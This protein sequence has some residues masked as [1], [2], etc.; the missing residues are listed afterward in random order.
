MDTKAFYTDGEKMIDDEL[1]KMRA[2]KKRLHQISQ[3]IE[4]F[5]DGKL[6]EKK[7]RVKL[8]RLKYPLGDE[9]PRTAEAAELA[10]K[11]KSYAAR[12]TAKKAELTDELERFSGVRKLRGEFLIDRNIVSLF[13]SVLTRTLGIPTA[14]LTRDLLVVKTC[15]FKILHDIVLNG[16]EWDGE[17]YVYFTAS[18][19]QIRTKRSVFIRESQLQKYGEKLM[20]GLSVEKINEMGGVNTNKYLAYLALCNSATDPWPGFDITKTIVV[21]DMETV[22]TGE[23]DYIDPET[24]QITRKVMGVP[25]THT[26]GCGMVRPDISKKNFMIRLPWVKGLLISFPFDKFVREQR[27]GGNTACG[28]VTDIYG[29][30]HDVLAED[31]QVIFTKS[32]F[33]LWKYYLGGWQEYQTKFLELGCEAGVCNVEPDHFDAAKINYQMLQTLKDLS[34]EELLSIGSNTINKLRRLS[35]DRETMLQLFG[36]TNQDGRKS[37]FQRCLNLYPE[38]L[39]DE[40]T[41]RTLRDV[42]KSVE[43]EARAGKLYV[44]GV[45]TFI[46][47]DLYAFC[48]WLFLGDENPSGLLRD[49][50]VYCDLFQAEKLDCLRAPHLSMEHA[51]RRNMVGTEEADE[52]KRWF[53][54]PAVYTSVNDLISKILQFD[55]DGDRSLVVAD[56]TIIAAAERN[57]RGVV[58]MYYEMKKAAAQQITSENIYQSMIRA[59]TG[60]N[61][62]QISNDITK[63]WNTDQEFSYEAIQMLCMENNF[64]IDRC[65]RTMQ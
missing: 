48:Q 14:Q 24:Y 10:A 52:I 8:E 13:E 21:D 31:I 26:D 33:K 9:L 44:D 1:S 18:A 27:R 37:A 38:L 4:G 6:T 42:R 61:I 49:G 60:G 23:V 25:I 45:Y 12:I 22:V 35:Y 3:T 64:V 41:K 46:S 32:Q 7:L 50:E 40:Y 2:E 11:A 16:F 47:P 17:R 53:K 19:G 55:V 34:D 36:A 59:Y 65:G 15:Y 28:T 62:G 56:E 54:T 29:V 51:V 5:Y 39:Q 63:I 30:E 20:C 57:G 58:P 43:T